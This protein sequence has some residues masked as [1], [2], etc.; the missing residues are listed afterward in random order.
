MNKRALMVGLGEV[1]WDLLPAGKVLGGAPT[2]FAYMSSVLGDEGV[3]ASR[4]GND[5]LGRDALAVMQGEGLCTSYLQYDGKYE[6]G[7]A[8][9]VLDEGG[10][11]K[12]T[13][14]EPVAW[15]HLQW[16]PAW[17]ELSAKV[18]VVCFGSLAQRSSVS[19][20]TIK[21]FLQN[22]PRSALR[23]CDANLREPFYSAEILRGSFRHADIVK[24]NSD[25]LVRIGSLLDIA[26]SDEP[27]LAQ[28]LIHA[29]DLKL[30]CI[31]R[32]A[33]GSMLV[34]REEAV[35]HAGFKVKVA[36]AVGAGDA[37][38]A[39]LAH[40]FIRDMRLEQISERAN[41]FGSWVA[42]QVGATPVIPNG[43][44]QQI[45]NGQPQ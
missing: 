7:T 18:D 19:A 27:S 20:E 25:E 35:E 40:F 36:D 23:I 6:T 16:T 2:N 8:G 42:S 34:S 22:V 43:R 21:R 12:F 11:P 24:V 29:F 41:R 44:L 3:V 37:F 1:L 9:V 17:E 31:T 33:R 38:T 28:G 26:G 13:I 39:C 5:E 32:G 14:K 4:V 45:L 10:Q 15:D 30:V